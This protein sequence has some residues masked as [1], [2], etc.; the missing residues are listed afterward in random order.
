MRRVGS[1]LR[2]ML[3]GALRRAHSERSQR[4]ELKLEG[5]LVIRLY[6]SEDATAHL[7]LERLRVYP[8]E[9]EWS[10]VLNSWPWPLPNPRPTPER[11]ESGI[12]MGLRGSW[13]I[14]PELIR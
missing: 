9:W 14:R 12:R 2:L 3:E 11:V 4:Q 13:P 6:I 8:S 7:L 10:S 5:G 1:Y